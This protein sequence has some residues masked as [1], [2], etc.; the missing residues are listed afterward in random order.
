M[1]L[2]TLAAVP[3]VGGVAKIGKSIKTQAKI[4]GEIAESNGF[5]YKGG[6]FLPS[7]NAE[8]GRWK[9]GKKT[10]T[11]G[12]ELIAPGQF[13]VQPTPFSRSIYAAALQDITLRTPEGLVFRPGIKDAL[14]NEITPDTGIRIGVKGVLG[15]E[16]LSVKELINA[17]NKG[18]RWFDV[19]P[20]AP[21]V[22]TK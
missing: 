16:E 14:G 11:A 2:A 15:K 20:D 22:R 6:Q 10:V 1:G 8:P 19:Q 7:T 3:V 4:G 5:F 13:E 12:K 18:Q 17:Y 21:I 9:I